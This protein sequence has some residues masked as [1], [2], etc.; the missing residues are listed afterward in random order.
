[1]CYTNENRKGDQRDEDA[2]PTGFESVVK[3]ANAPPDALKPGAAL[4][5]FSIHKE[6]LPMRRR[7]RP[8]EFGFAR[9]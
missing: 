3:I 8:S 5:P 6:G 9:R 2:E 4:I 1:L 7:I